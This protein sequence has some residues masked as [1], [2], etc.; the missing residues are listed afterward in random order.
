MFALF[1]PSL[2]GETTLQGATT[3]FKYETDL[4]EIWCS[5]N[6]SLKEKRGMRP[7]L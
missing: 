4:Y 7:S 2:N 3:S 1:Q 5:P 6:A